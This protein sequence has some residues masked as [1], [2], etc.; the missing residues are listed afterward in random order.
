MEDSPLSSSIVAGYTVYLLK[1]YIYDNHK[2]KHGGYDKE[3]NQG[4]KSVFLC[5]R[6]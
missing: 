6:C 5:L 4:P 3:A 2:K 1:V